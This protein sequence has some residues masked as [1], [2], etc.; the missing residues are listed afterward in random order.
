MT[1]LERIT[2]DNSVA[3]FPD[4]Y[5]KNNQTIESAI[6]NVEVTMHGLEKLCKKKVDRAGLETLIEQKIK[7]ILGD[8]DFLTIDKVK[9][10]IKQML[11]D[12]GLIGDIIPGDNGVQGDITDINTK[13]ANLQT[14]IANLQ[15]QLNSVKLDADNRLIGLE[16]TQYYPEITEVDGGHQYVMKK[17]M[18]KK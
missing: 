6:G 10:L 15:A 13:I 17:Y 5:N 11:E 18:D 9:E 2:G 12:Y 14:Q 16:N 1:K 7:E 4:I 8:G 3:G